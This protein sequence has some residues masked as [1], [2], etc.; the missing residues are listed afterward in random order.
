RRV[1]DRPRPVCSRATA[2]GR[3]SRQHLLQKVGTR[4]GK[5]PRRV[6]PGRAG[7]ARGRPCAAA[8][9][10]AQTQADRCRCAHYPRPVLTTAESAGAVQT[11]RSR[12]HQ[13][14]SSDDTY[15]P[16]ALRA[17]PHRRDRGRARL[18]CL[19][20][21]RRDRQRRGPA[22]VLHRAVRRSRI[23][24]RERGALRP[25]LD[26]SRWTLAGASVSADLAT[27]RSFGR[28]DK[29]G[30]NDELRVPRDEHGPVFRAPWEAEAFA[31]A[32]SLKESGL[33]TWTEWA[34]TLGDEIKKAQTAADP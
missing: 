21:H 15:A 19:P 1:G 12:A 5:A 24:G 26:R 13:E 18:P 29:S 4:H 31:L 8:R 11:G 14:H 2:A 9:Q 23:V 22:M 27:P 3:L 25:S 30:R 7:R 32:V 16:A 20:R 28:N 33:F 34:T 6:W 10:S 17:Q